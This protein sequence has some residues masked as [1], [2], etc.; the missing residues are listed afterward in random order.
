MLR[1]AYRVNFG[2]VLEFG[3]IALRIFLVNANKNIAYTR[4]MIR[5]TPPQDFDINAVKVRNIEPNN[6]LNI[7]ITC[8]GN[9]VDGGIAVVRRYLETFRRSITSSML[10]FL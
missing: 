8:N 9:R 6:A 3:Y 1:R 7:R 2:F 5:Q 4:P 10:W